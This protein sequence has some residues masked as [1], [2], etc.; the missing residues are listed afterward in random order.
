MIKMRFLIWLNQLL[1]TDLLGG[2]SEDEQISDSL[3]EDW[4]SDTGG[5]DRYAG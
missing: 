1:L 4:L 5:F 3:G 2:E